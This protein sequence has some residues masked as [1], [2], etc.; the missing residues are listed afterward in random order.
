VPFRRVRFG[1][2]VRGGEDEIMLLEVGRWNEW[3]GRSSSSSEALCISN[4][5][6]LS[7]VEWGI[8]A[9]SETK[10]CLL[11]LTEA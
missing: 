8:V 10:D 7:A 5:G 11:K 6:D 3:T 9:E 4:I 2:G 1:G